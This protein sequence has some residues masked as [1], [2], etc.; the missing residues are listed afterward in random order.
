MKCRLVDVD[1][2]SVMKKIIKKYQKFI[3]KEQKKVLRR[4]LLVLSVVA[5]N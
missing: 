4:E 5:A 3:K 2:S 1:L